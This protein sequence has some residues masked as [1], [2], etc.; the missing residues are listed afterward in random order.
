M[1][2]LKIMIKLIAD[3][4][5]D[6]SEEMIS[7]YNIGIA[8]LHILI[9]NKTY[10]DKIDIKATEFFQLLPTLKELPT[11][12]MPSPSEYLKIIDLAISEGYTEILCIC[13]SSGTSGSYQS[14]ELAKSLFYEDNP[15]S[16]VKLYI[17]DSLSMSHGSGWL[18]LKTAKLLNEG[19]GFTELIEFCETTK[20]RIKHFLCVDDLSNLVKSGRISNAGALLGKALGIKP[21]MSMKNGQGVVISKERGWNKV[22]KTYTT[23]FLNRV[24]INITDFLI[25]GYSSSIIIAETLKEKLKATTEFKGEIFIMQMGVSVG[26]HVGLGGLSM[27]FCEKTI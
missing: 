1:E 8:P 11:T 10:R 21:I 26:T 7:K 19:K 3:S 20:K 4:T 23:E 16:Q 6:L 9:D 17:V 5:C 18:L 14:A 27:F 2:E 22:I 13:M 24:D 12:S 25:I 15:N